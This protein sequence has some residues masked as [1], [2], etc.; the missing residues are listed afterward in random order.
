MGCISEMGVK[1]AKIYLPSCREE[2][3]HTDNCLH[4]EDAFGEACS[5]GVLCGMID[6]IGL[7]MGVMAHPA[8]ILK[9]I[10]GIVKMPEFQ[11]IIEQQKGQAVPI[12]VECSPPDSPPW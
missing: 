7:V 4:A 3:V 5:F 6:E 10:N 1:N 2:V 12:K 11:A 8:V 9:C